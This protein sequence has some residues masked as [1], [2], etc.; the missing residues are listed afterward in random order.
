MLTHYVLAFAI[1]TLSVIAFD[2]LNV[3][4]FLGVPVAQSK[5]MQNKLNRNIRKLRASWYIHQKKVKRA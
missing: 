1:A 5:I 2:D 4:R 3:T